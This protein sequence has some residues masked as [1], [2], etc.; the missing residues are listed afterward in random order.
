MATKRSKGRITGLLSL[1]CESTVALQV[2]DPVHITGDYT[3]AKA[4]GSKFCIGHVGVANVKRDRVT[5]QYP[6][7]NV[8]GDVAVEA[9][10]FEVRT[11]E[12]GAAIAAGAEVGWNG[13]GDL[14]TAGAGVAT[15]GVALMEAAGAGDEIDVLVR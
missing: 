9:R 7:S 5:A 8:P 3:V 15:I 14:V 13:A 10:G 6:V 12:S 11:L 1:T 4:D 2:G